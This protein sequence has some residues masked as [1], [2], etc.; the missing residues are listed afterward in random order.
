VNQKEKSQID[1]M[2]GEG[3]MLMRYRKSLGSTVIS[4]QRKR[5]CGEDSRE[6]DEGKSITVH[7]KSCKYHDEIH[8][9]SF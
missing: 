1:K 5:G 4:S 6:K 8:S 3:G 2:R 9:L 7:A